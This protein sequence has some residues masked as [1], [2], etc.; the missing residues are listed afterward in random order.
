MSGGDPIR[1][2]ALA[3]VVARRLDACALDE[4]RVIDRVLER[5]E[6]G[7]QRYGALDLSVPR[8]W[9]R[10]RAEERLDALVYDVCAELAAEDAE[11]AELHEDAARELGGEG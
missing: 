10:E 8:N 2:S 11:R 5:L 9:R 7:R 1:R 3:R 4:L 6:L